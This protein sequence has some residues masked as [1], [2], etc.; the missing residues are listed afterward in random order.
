MD[1]P[2]QTNQQ[3][4]IHPQSFKHPSGTPKQPS[5]K[6]TWY[7]VG[8]AVLFLIVGGLFVF[9]KK[10]QQT[11]QTQQTTTYQQPSIGPTVLPT[12]RSKSPGIITQVF[13]SRSIDAKSGAALTP[14]AIFFTKDK[15]I[16]AVLSL[17]NPPVGTRIEYNRYLNGKYLDRRSISITKANTTK[18]LFN[19]DLKSSKSRL[20]GEY[21]IK[22]YTNGIFEKEISYTVQ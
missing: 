11:L 17:N 4:V 3:D 6:T 9:L 15:Q 14:T 13:M 7:I 21:R 22:F 8:V 16:H 18:S 1:T 20:K 2:A 19:W 10:S 5:S 12:T